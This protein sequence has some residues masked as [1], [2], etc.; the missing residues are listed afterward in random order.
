MPE[1]RTIPRPLV[2][3][4]VVLA[5][6][7]TSPAGAS[8]PER[9]VPN[10]RPFFD[11]GFSIP[12]HYGDGN[13]DHGF[14]FGFGLEAEQSPRMSVF[15]RFEWNRLVGEWVPHYSYTVRVHAADYSVGA[16]I[17]LRVRGPVRPYTE[18]SVGVRF[19]GTERGF[20]A[21]P[22]SVAGDS[23]VPD[24]EGVAAIV[25]L[26]LSTAPP[27][28]AGLFLDSGWDFMVRNP[29]QYGLVPIRLGIQFP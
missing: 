6:S 7:A 5:F 15:F 3:M 19:A 28:G 25:R 24:K 23:R 4:G 20:Y 27:G 14:G 17:H 21:E 10:V 26:G 9:L 8:S 2:V 22:L 1:L 12:V 13:L 11:S 18:A 16:R 29:D